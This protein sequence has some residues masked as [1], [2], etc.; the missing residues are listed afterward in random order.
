[1]Y[2]GDSSG[3]IGVWSIECA[4]NDGSDCAELQFV[5]LFQLSEFQARRI[6]HYNLTILLILLRIT[7]SSG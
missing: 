1:M 4:M 6:F 7:A 3:A 5:K 2:S